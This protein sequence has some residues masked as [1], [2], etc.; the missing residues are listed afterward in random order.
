MKPG[1]IMDF[2]MK[3][4]NTRNHITTVEIMEVR[5]ADEGN[6]TGTHQYLVCRRADNGL[7]ILALAS[8]LFPKD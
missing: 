8:E 1:D 7:V 4:G 5:L 2:N 6:G 3:R